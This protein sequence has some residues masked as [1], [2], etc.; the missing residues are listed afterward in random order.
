LFWP[1]RST[2]TQLSLVRGAGPAKNKKRRLQRR[3]IYRQSLTAERYDEETTKFR[4]PKS[5]VT[6]VEIVYGP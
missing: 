1:A 4:K 6:P 5:K 3:A 2:K